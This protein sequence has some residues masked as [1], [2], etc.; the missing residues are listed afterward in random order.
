[1]DRKAGKT[2]PTFYTAEKV[3]NARRNI[4]RY[5]WARAIRDK[6]VEAAAPFM[7]LSDDDL[8]HLP[9]SQSVPRS[10]GVLIRYRQ[11]LKGSPGPEGA[12]INKYGNYPWI[13]DPIRY[14]WKLKSPVTGELYPSND[15][16]RYYESGLNEHGEF[17][18]ELAKKRG[19]QYL[20]NELY[21]ERG[22][23]WG[24]DDG[25][26]W[27]DE[28]G[29]V[30]T[31]IAYYNHWALWATGGGQASHGLITRGLNALRDAYLYTGDLRYAHKG[32]ILLDRVAD[33]YPDMDITAHHWYLGFDNGDP[34]GHSAQGNILHDIWETGLVKA[35]TFAYDAFFPAI[36]QDPELIRFLSDKE[37]QYKLKYPKRSAEDIKRNIE[38]R[39]LRLIYPG[40]KN[41]RIR[42]NIGMHQSAL[43]LAAVV[44]DEEGTSKEWLDF[45]F[46]PG[47]LI[48]QPDPDA[49]FGRRYM[50]T[51]GNFDPL[52]YNDIDRDGWGDEASPGYNTGWLS[53]FLVVAQVVDGYER[54]P[55]YDLYRNPKF[56][57][58]FKAYYPLIMLGQYTPSIGDTGKT[59]NPGLLGS[60][61]IDLLGFEK[62]G[63]PVL[64]QLACMRNGGT[65]EGLHGSVFSAEP[66]EIVKRIEEVLR[67]SG[68][69]QLKSTHS[70]GY[71]F[72]ALRDGEG[73]DSRAL[74]CYYGRNTGHGHLDTLN[75]GLYA[76]GL[77]LSPDLGYPEVTGNDPE[78]RN[79]TRATV[80]HNTVVVDRRSQKSQVVAIPRHLDETETVKLIDIEAPAVYPQTEM[81]RRTAALIRIDE[82][83][84]YAVDFFRVKGGSDHVFSF[85][86]A[87]GEAAAYGLNLAA[88]SGGS[89]AGADVPHKDRPFDESNPQCGFNYL[90]GVERDMSPPD[91]FSVEWRVRDT[92]K[93][94]KEKRDI[95]LRLTMLG[96]ADDVALADGAPPQNKPGNPRSLRY[97]LVH[98][99][100]E[101]LESNF[102]SV[103]E[104]YEGE[105]SIKEIREVPVMAR[106]AA[107]APAAAPAAPIEAK[108]VRVELNDGRVDYIVSAIDNQRM[109]EVDGKF[110]FQGSFGFVRYRNGRAAYTYMH[111]GAWIET[112][113]QPAELKPPSL[114]G[115]VV[116]FTKE[117]S[118]TNEMTVRM[119][120]PPEM[121]AERLIGKFIHVETDGVRNGSYEIKSAVRIGSSAVSSESG[122]LYRIGV[123]DITFIRGMNDMNDRNLGFIYDIREGALFSIPLTWETWLSQQA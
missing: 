56:L 30:W 8:W 115:T 123:G 93:V 25:W 76:F 11:R 46:K 96:E 106:S 95:R 60:L 78:N 10:L 72:S 111:D 36:G 79:W 37:K 63:D 32:L 28:D 1:M 84:S 29:D 109:Y 90:S 105:S 13:V 116:D 121:D 16:K 47:K 34:S 49:P 65:L 43:A 61:E 19:A 40:V 21:P 104:S 4:G 27:K 100:G 2:K 80:S 83:R 98:R 54:Y 120:L 38:D 14:P 24:V 75:I 99:S 33:L 26:G 87:E 50:V 107:N 112:D 89:Y 41:S 85:H 71:G 45:V 20:K 35:F 18:P 57:K 117:L 5:G 52:F 12:E 42:G 103:L 102:T 64:A 74:W 92:W 68:P 110:A 55:E 23:T 86:A 9:T 15:F 114:S 108:A 39:I 59:G 118:D 7:E 66:E 51:G 69:F 94:H 122:A 81:Y 113:V 101:R 53:N 77:D 91:K 3:A 62:T 70:T 22:E 48:K 82:K 73:S 6:A 17:D 97:V 67:T 44:L 31:F 88:Q 58:M 119:A